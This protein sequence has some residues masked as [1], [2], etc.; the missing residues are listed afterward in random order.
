M[1]AILSRPQCVKAIMC[2]AYGTYNI[3]RTIS[4]NKIQLTQNLS[5]W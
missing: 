1:A 5:E 3:L 4:G 2:P